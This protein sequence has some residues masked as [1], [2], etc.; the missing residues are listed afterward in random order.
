MLTL[1]VLVMERVFPAPKRCCSAPGKELQGQPAALLREGFAWFET[2]WNLKNVSE[3]LKVS[4]SNPCL[5]A[6][7]ALS[8]RPFSPIVI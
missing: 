8:P 6:L 4:S 7:H 5:P 2:C 1:T 3:K